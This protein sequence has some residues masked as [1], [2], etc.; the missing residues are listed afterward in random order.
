MQALTREQVREV[1]RRA[2]EDLGIPGIVLM[3]NASRSAADAVLDFLEMQ[4]HLVAADARVTIVCGGGNNGGDGYAMARHLFNEGV[5]VAI[6]AAVPIEALKG[7]ARTNAEICSRMGLEIVTVGHASEIATLPFA[8][9]H[10][11]LLVDAILG[12]GFE[13]GGAVREPLDQFILSINA[14]REQG[15]KVVAVDVPSG[16][17]ANTGQPATTTVIADVTVTFVA[18]KVGFF[19]EEPQKFLGEVTVA[20]IGCP[21]GLVQQVLS[22]SAG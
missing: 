20:G 17:D 3:E 12:T 19:H 6:C 4:M 16:L 2:T 22:E 18:P 5:K 7:D 11:D 21:P 14:A 8:P 1:D 10:A 9:P 15:V 13:G